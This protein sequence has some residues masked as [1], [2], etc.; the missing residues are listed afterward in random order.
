MNQSTQGVPQFPSTPEGVVAALL[1][2]LQAKTTEPICF[3]GTDENG[4]WDGSEIIL[5]RSSACAL[6]TID[7]FGYGAK[8][9]H[10]FRFTG[11]YTFNITEAWVTTFQTTVTD[12]S[13]NGFSGR[14]QGRV[15]TQIAGNT[16]RGLTP[17][18]HPRG[19]GAGAPANG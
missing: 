15:P 13:R 6:A 16:P 11:S 5:C 8:S 10:N 12:W 4:N 1:Y 18:G 17:L 14:L 7:A 3:Q 19:F 9:H 2:L